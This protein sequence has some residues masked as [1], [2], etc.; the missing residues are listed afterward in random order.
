MRNFNDK[1]CVVE[2]EYKRINQNSEEEIDIKTRKVQSKL[3]VMQQK[4][5]E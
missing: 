2:T 1:I 4:F 3:F 5:G